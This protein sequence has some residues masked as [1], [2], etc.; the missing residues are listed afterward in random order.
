MT[1]Q[2]LSK[3]GHILPVEIW[4]GLPAEERARVVRLIVK[5][6]FMLITTKLDCTPKEANNVKPNG[7]TQSTR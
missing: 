3:P 2:G 1:E 6:A 7:R 4:T 5:L